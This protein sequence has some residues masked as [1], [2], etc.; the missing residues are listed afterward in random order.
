[1]CISLSFSYE[2]SNG[3]SR[4][5]QAEIRNAGSENE[6]IAVRGTISWIAADGEKYTIDFVA[7]ENGFQPTG[8]HL[9]Q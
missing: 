3:I 8:A 7:D 4:S 9:P 6:A 5:E 1:M 2:T